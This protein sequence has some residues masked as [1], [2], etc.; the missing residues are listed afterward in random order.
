MLQSN[1]NE[2]RAELSLPTEIDYFP[3]NA[4][5]SDDERTLSDTDSVCTLSS[6]STNVS[7]VQQ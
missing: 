5:S 6:V 2:I 7:N 1:I 3:T 4:H